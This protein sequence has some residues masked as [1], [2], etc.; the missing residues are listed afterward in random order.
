MG[1][2]VRV[3]SDH[4]SWVAYLRSLPH[5][6]VLAHPTVQDSGHG[7]LK[8]NAHETY[9]LMASVWKKHEFDLLAV[10]KDAGNACRRCL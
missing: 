1:L 7:L 6:I 5:G 4:A 2:S 9:G 10:A 8:T 3:F